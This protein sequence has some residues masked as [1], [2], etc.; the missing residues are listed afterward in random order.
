MGLKFLPLHVWDREFDSRL[1]LA[2]TLANEGNSVLIGNEHNIRPMLGKSK[3]QFLLR[4]G[5][6]CNG[7]RHIWDRDVAN[8][9]GTVVLHDEEGVNNMHLELQEVNSIKNLKLSKCGSGWGLTGK[10]RNDA[11]EGIVNSCTQLAWSKI[12]REFMINSLENERARRKAEER[13]LVSSSIRF[14]MLG[15]FGKRLNSERIAATKELFGKFVL[16]LDNFSAET[17]LN[18]RGEPTMADGL[19]Y[20]GYK[21]EDIK[22]ETRKHLQDI[23]SERKARDEFATIIIRMAMQNPSTIFVMRPHPVMD[24]SYWKNK[25]SKVSN[26]IVI[27]GGNVQP[28][29]YSACLTIHSGCTTGLE[30]IASNTNTVDISKMI[31]NRIPIISEALVSHG[32]KRTKNDQELHELIK[33]YSS[34]S[35][36]DQDDTDDDLTQEFSGKD[37]AYQKVAKIFEQNAMLVQEKINNGLDI[38]NMDHIY[39][40]TSALSKAIHFGARYSGMECNDMEILKYALN[41]QPLRKS[42]HV[43]L[44]E[45]A[46]RTKIFIRVLK[47]YGVNLQSVELRKISSNLF[48]IQRS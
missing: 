15:S 11:S 17:V 27:G 40:G 12:H 46:K 23:D 34:S 28:W 5:F 41:K 20:M 47:E 21:E 14:D 42:R 25:M 16:V 35:L 48:L 37:L 45:V 9:N 1:I 18:R 30:A 32:N 44:G 31:P 36:V 43:S 39:G 19:R 7:D 33:E 3:Y 24:P 38:D 6:A 2:L 4:S 22:K 10:F 8:A 26:I 29:I 13:I